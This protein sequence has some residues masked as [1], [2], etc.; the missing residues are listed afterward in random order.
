[1][2]ICITRSEKYVYSETFIRNQIEGLSNYAEIF[3]IHSGRYPERKEDGTLLSP[4]L[5]WLLHKAIKIAVG[6]N[7]FFSNYGV[8]KHLK[9]NKIDLIWANYGISGAHMV[10]AAKALNIPLITIFHGHDATDKKLLKIY[11]RKYARL[12]KQAAYII[13]V[14]EEMKKRLINIGANPEKLKVIP[15]GINIENF[16]P[17][18]ETPQKMNFLAVGRFTAKK[19]PTITIRAF[20]KVLQKYPEATLTMVGKKSGL[21]EECQKLVDELGIQNSVIFTGIMDQ[22]QIAGMMRTCF[23]YV[24]H[25][26]IAPNGDMEGTPLSILEAGASGIPI[27]STRHAGIKEAVVHGS[28]GYLVDE[29]DEDGM[30]RYMIELCDNPEMAKSFGLNGRKHIEENYVLEKQIRKYYALAQAAAINK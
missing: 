18:L 4:K 11:K 14:S 22:T 24:Q 20:Y 16:K 17:Q 23:A 29:K 8:K 30:A 2:R 5:F 6:R 3:N 13:A 9:E 1:M 25:S 26:I 21:Y 28:T 7:N 15:Y 19:G 27:V 12:F 10:P